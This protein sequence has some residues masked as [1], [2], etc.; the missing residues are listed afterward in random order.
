MFGVFCIAD[1]SYL[2]I[3]TV[4]FCLCI[5]ICRS[6]IRR[7]QSRGSFNWTSVNITVFTCPFAANSFK[8]GKTSNDEN[9]C[10][11]NDTS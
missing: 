8:N 9:D 2:L 11:D 5:F 10:Q 3:T 1:K 7:G 6:L 4:M